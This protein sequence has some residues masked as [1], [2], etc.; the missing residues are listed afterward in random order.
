MAQ[1]HKNMKAEWT[2][3]QLMIIPTTV[4]SPKGPL[5]HQWLTFPIF[6]Y[7]PEIIL[8]PGRLRI[9]LLG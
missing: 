9:G 4:Y 8:N 1:G 6:L 3:R 5:S 2:N 7:A